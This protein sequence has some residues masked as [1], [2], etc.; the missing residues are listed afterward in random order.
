[1][2]WY[3]KYVYRTLLGECRRQNPSR[4]RRDAPDIGDPAR[5]GERAPFYLN[6]V[7]SSFLILKRLQYIWLPM[8]L[9]I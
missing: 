3:D 7:F 5:Y 6:D 9:Q 4:R 1:M 8:R 2:V